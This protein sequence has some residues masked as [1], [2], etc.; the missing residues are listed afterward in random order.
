MLRGRPVAVGGDGPRGVISSA[1]YEARKFGVHS[2]MP[3]ARALKRCPQLILV[4]GD[5]R[6]Y[7]ELS[8]KVF[9]I[10]S[11]YTPIY[12]A[13]G[14]D[15]GYLDMT[16][17][18]SL[19]GKPLEAAAKIRKEI[20]EA[21]GLTC[22]IGIA[23]NRL[24]AK[25]TTDFC[26]PNNMH[27]VPA[28]TE[29]AFL[30]PMPV[31]K[32]P[33]CGKVTT[34]WLKDR[35]ITTIGKLQRYPLDVLERH[36]GSFGHYLHQSAWGKGSTEFNEEAKTRSISREQTFAEDIADSATLEREL[37]EMCAELGK[38]LREHDD[39]A[40]AIRL[41]LRY[42]PFHT[43]TR[44]RVL[45]TTTQADRTLFDAAKAL[46]FENWEEGTPLRLLGVG[47]VI[48]TG[49][50]QLGLFEDRTEEKKLDVLDQLKDSIRRKFGAKALKTGR[51][52]DA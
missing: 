46:F 31:E 27:E 45:A 38:Q 10:V 9:S 34:A 18:E 39:F 25:I 11:R 33:G 19:W 15:E 7:S 50:R 49:E 29:A 37:W 30:A 16:G 20:H 22:S 24:V 14:I 23:S 40:R 48:G 36:L 35:E 47:A 26:K 8:K 5:Y 28:G 44:S 2:A 21:T 4:R 1:S 17:T 6:Y 43:V 13:T 41:K 3:T 52:G 12:E 32:L 42:P 51:D